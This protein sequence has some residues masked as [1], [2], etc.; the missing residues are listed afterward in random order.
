MKEF[1][2]AKVWPLQPGVKGLNALGETVDLQPGV[3]GWMILK[4]AEAAVAAGQVQL[5]VG[6]T[7]Q[8]LKRP[9][10]TA[11]VEE[12]DDLLGLDEVPETTSPP[13]S[14][15]RRGARYNHRKMEAEK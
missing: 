3:P 4:A 7:P 9:T 11:K 5:M 8:S 2:T 13:P 12:V 1:T 6:Q 14:K 10:Y 15:R